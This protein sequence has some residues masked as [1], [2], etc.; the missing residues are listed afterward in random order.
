MTQVRAHTERL[1][2][3]T[4]WF[5]LHRIP[6]A[7]QIGSIDKLLGEVEADENYI[8]GKDVAIGVNHDFRRFNLARSFWYSASRWSISDFGTETLFS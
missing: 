1:T 3:K 4:A 8:G 6:H 2:Q 7:M 5:M